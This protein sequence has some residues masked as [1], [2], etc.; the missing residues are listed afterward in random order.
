MLW[1][2]RIDDLVRE[3]EEQLRKTPLSCCIIAEHGGEGRIAE[4][5]RKALTEGFASAS[6]IAETVLC[7]C[8]VL[9]A[10]NKDGKSIPKK[11]P[12][13]MLQQPHSLL[14][15]KLGDHVAQYSPH[16]VEPFVGLADVLQAEV[17]EQ[18]LLHNKDGHGFA[19]LAAGLHD[20][21]TEWDYL[22]CEQEVDDFA[23]VILDEGADYAQGS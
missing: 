21:Q 2:G 15:D 1:S 18:D 14:L 3:R 9:K 16:S 4:W 23:R 10:S 22:G 12:N 11:T 6:I 20:A 5:F 17:I 19:K 13:D 7:Q 8:Q